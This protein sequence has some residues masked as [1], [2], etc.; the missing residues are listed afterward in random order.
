MLFIIFYFYD[1]LN[2][3]NVIIATLKKHTKNR[4]HQKKVAT[5]KNTGIPFLSN[6]YTSFE[7]RGFLLLYMLLIIISLIVFKDFIVSKKL[8]LFTDIG[9]DSINSYWPTYTLISDYLGNGTFPGWSFQTG[10][11]QNIFPQN[12]GDPFRYIYYLSDR[13]TIPY[14]IFYVELVKIFIAAG[15]FYSF[16][17]ILNL[18]TVSSVFGALVYGFSGYMIVGGGWYIF[19]TE[20][21]YVA[22]LLYSFERFYQKGSWVLFAVSV[23]LIAAYNPF[24][25]YLQCLLIF[26]YSAVRIFNQ[27]DLKIKQFLLMEGK[28]IL[29]GTI[30][31]GISAFFFIPAA[32]LFLQSPRVG[33]ESGLFSSLSSVS[34]FSVSDAGQLRTALARLFSTDLLGNGSDFKGWN[35]YLEAPVFY[36]SILALLLFPQLFLNI[37]KKRKVSYGLLFAVALIMILIPYFR[38]M[39]W[40]FTGNY[41]RTFSLFV[42][43]LLIFFSVR[44]L[45]YLIRQ[46]KLNIWLLLLTSLLLLSVLYL[47]PVR[48][49]QVTVVDS[50]IRSN[51]KILIILYAGILILAYFKRTRY[52]GI[53]LLVVMLTIELVYMTSGSVNNR[54]VLTSEKL[55]EKSGYN[56]FTNN[57][58]E[59][60]KSK[61]SSFYRVNKDYFSDYAGH[62]GLNDAKYQNYFGTSSYHSF[63]QKYYI[64]FLDAFGEI[65]AKNEEQT[66]WARGLISNPLLQSFASVKY[67]LSKSDNPDF[68]KFNNNLIDSVGDV[69]IL[70]NINFIPLG[71]AYDTFIKRSLFNKLGKLQKDMSVFKAFIIDDN[72]FHDFEGF[73]EF[74]SRD[75]TTDF[76]FTNLNHKIELLKQDTLNITSFTENEIA[77]TV[78]SNSEKLLFFSIPYDSGWKAALDD[79]DIDIHVVNAG[80]MG[81][82]IPKGQHKV[83][84]KYFPPYIKSGAVISVLA[85]ILAVVLFIFKRKI[86]L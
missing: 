48:I 3:K 14:L 23:A 32:D 80:L 11:G 74:Q 55:K 42:T 41:Y 57:A 5:A 73:N 36:C 28:L 6:L 4:N 33:G 71:F 35:N 27:P 24:N 81:I 47:I 54:K 18:S 46:Q 56:D 16:L 65:D 69:K 1:L 25:L 37:S 60:L 70:K 59:L 68:L 15:L 62:L 79:H 8:Y 7:N 26:V 76:S 51:I 85:L 84:L 50:G 38:Y 31:L 2:N 49:N 10:M 72:S 58:I 66:R 82:K 83:V 39:F 43:L 61:D 52:T 30:G 63:N 20:V 19:S 40:L 21:V 9:S 29:M 17:R 53:I 64:E 78:N 22:L 77:G 12:F 86:V 75:T 67:N 34:K 45:D 13:E 44:S